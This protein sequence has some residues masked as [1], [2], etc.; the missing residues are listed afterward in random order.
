VRKIRLLIPLAAALAVVTAAPAALA[1]T[2]VVVPS[3]SP[4]PDV[5]A[6]SGLWARTA[7]DAWAVGVFGETA[8]EDEQGGLTLHWNGTAWTQVLAPNPQF[9][10]ERLNGVSGTAAND[11]WAVG[12]AAV[13]INQLPK[14]PWALHWDGAAW[15]EVAVPTGP[16]PGGTG[17]GGL[18]GVVAL[19]ATDAW[20]VG[21]SPGVTAIAEHWDGTAWT[22]ATVPNVKLGL[23]GVA[24]VSAAELWAVGD[25]V[26]N[27]NGTRSGT[28]MHFTG[29]S[30]QLAPNQVTLP[31]STLNVTLNAVTVVNAR[32]V[33]A[34]GSFTDNL[35]VSHALIQHFN[36]VS[37]T[38]VPT[39]ATSGTTTHTS[40]GGVAARSATDVFAVG[41]L[42]HTDLTEDS[43]I[44]HWNGTA[45]AAETVPHTTAPDDG[46]AA[47]A[48]TP[49]GS[50]LWAAGQSFQTG[51]VRTTLILR[52]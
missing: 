12:A 20:A 28:I 37:W 21:K 29:G 6:L 44:L 9:R 14:V 22:L 3:P 47:A 8:N 11:V 36:G 4:A 26:L 48:V 10:N 7:A 18:R 42:S 35:S 17:R 52:G 16:N 32:D 40:L 34:V 23:N 15:R 13:A 31:S 45:W 39:P 38:R 5:N 50:P 33:W 19:S 49:G 46:L 41:G 25:G 43:Y 27:A 24:A 2:W 51:T 30:W 1:A